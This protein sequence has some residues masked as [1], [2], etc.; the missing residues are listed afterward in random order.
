MLIVDSR[1]FQGGAPGK[2][3]RAGLGALYALYVGAAL[4]SQRMEIVVAMSQSI[5]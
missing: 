2:E 3:R 1:Q 5:H 4:A